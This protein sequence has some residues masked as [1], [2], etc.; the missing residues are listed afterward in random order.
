MTN[1]FLK[2]SGGIFS[3][4][5]KDPEIYLEISVVGWGKDSAIG[6]EF[7]VGR[8]SW[9]TYWGEEGFFRISMYTDN[10]GVMNDCT[11]GIPKID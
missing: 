6:Q 2:Y 7:W 11:Y 5:L 8:K 4:K 3:Q 1:K 9:G 10:L